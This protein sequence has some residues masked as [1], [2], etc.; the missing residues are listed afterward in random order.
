M[1]ECVSVPLSQSGTSSCVHATDEGVS[2]TVDVVVTGVAGLF[3][4]SGVGVVAVTGAG[5]S[6]IQLGVLTGAGVD[7]ISF[8][9]T[10]SPPNDDS[11]SL[12]H[13][14]VLWSSCVSVASHA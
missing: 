7:C 14:G 13:S 11:D 6:C 2:V 9:R 5:D 12:S 10:S 3:I 4:Q 8:A 1:S